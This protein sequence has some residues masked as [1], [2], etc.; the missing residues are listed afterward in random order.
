MEWIELMPLP[1]CLGVVLYV[2]REMTEHEKNCSIKG[3]IN[4][5]AT[6]QTEI[7]KDINSIKTHLMGG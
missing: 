3:M 6:R 4:L 7:S 5:I 1:L 2:K